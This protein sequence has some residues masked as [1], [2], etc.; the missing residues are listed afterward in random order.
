MFLVLAAIFTLQFQR[1]SEK[2]ILIH[3][4]KKVNF[5]FKA[6]TKKTLVIWRFATTRLGALFAQITGNKTKP[7]LH[8][9]S[10]DFKAVFP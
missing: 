2:S 3:V 8:A 6:Q 9:Y 1:E 5:A 4:Q 7:K 10:S